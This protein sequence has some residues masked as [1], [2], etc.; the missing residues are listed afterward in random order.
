MRF[1]LSEEQRQFRRE[2]AEFVKN[3]WGTSS[4]GGTGGSGVDAEGDDSIARERAFKQKLAE[5]GWLGIAIPKEYGGA[6]KTPLEQFLFVEE[7]TYWGAPH[8]YI[9]VGFVAPTLI[10]YGSEEQRQRFLR[11]LVQGDVEFCLGY[12]EPEA[13][14]DLAGLETRIVEDGDDLVITGTKMYTTNAHRVEYCWLAGRTDPN[15][16]KHKGIS[17]VIVPLASEGVTIRPL[18]TAGGE[19]TNQVFFDGVRIPKSNLVGEMNRG[20]YYVAVALDFERFNGFPLGAI[21]R[22]FDELVAIVAETSRDGELLRDAP[23][24]QEIIGELATKLDAAMTVKLQTVEMAE[25]GEIPSTEASMLKVLASDLAQ[26]IAYGASRLLGPEALIKKGAPGAIASGRF[27]QALRSTVLQRF[28][29]GTNEIMK[30]II[31]QRGLGL[32][33]D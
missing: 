25:R 22:M 29:G 13:G 21:R 9:G 17:L 12:S 8:S 30:N 16:P 14:S 15:V 2:V 4:V 24:A 27:E 7:V 3:E 18:H 26:D 28:A 11:P 23:W 10:R 6:G 20:W 1:V 5:R 32:P 19:R 31:A 33:R